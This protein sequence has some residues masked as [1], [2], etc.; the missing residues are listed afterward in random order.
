MSLLFASKSF[1]KPE[2]ELLKKINNI[3]LIRKGQHIH[4]NAELNHL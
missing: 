1:Y 2:K 3:N 4:Q